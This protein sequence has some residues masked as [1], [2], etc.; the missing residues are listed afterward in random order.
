M[1]T[2]RTTDQTVLVVDDQPELADLHA[3]YLQDEYTIR[4]AYG[5][6]AGLGALDTKVDVVLLDREMPITAGADVIREI[7]QR[8]L[9]PGIAFLT[10]VAPDFDILELP[11]D[12]YL[13]KPVGPDAVRETVERLLAVEDGPARQ[14]NALQTKRE[15]LEAEKRDAELER[16]E[17]FGR[18]LEDIDLLETMM[19][20]LPDTTGR[21]IPNRFG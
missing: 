12:A 19:A 13:H 3:A 18:L 17:S 1:S 6:D 9:D 4:T 11:I 14:L 21:K 10:G 7:Q 8:E 15:L 20:E 2:Y 16:A 5:G